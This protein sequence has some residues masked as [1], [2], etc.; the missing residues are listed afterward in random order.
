MESITDEGSATGDLRVHRG[1][2]YV[3]GQRVSLGDD[4]LCSSQPD[5][6][7]HAG[8]PLWLDPA[9]PGQPH[10]LVYLMLREQ[11]VSAVEDPALRDV[12]LGGPDTSQRLRILQRIIR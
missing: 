10:E 8:D 11:E 3:G 2:A 12:A 5:W 4:I 1:T 7:D 9:I 6:Q